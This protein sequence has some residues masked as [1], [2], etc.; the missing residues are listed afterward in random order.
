MVQL[1]HGVPG[2]GQQQARQPGLLV[3]LPR[4]VRRLDHVLGVTGVDPVAVDV[5]VQ[6]GG[7]PVPDREGG[8]AFSGVGEPVQLGQRRG[9][10]VSVTLLGQVPEH[11]TGR[12]RG[13]L[14]IIPHQAHTSA[15]VD[16]LPDHGR[17]VAGAGHPGLVDDHQRPRPHRTTHGGRR[18]LTG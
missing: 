3:G 11:P 18:T 9:G 14:L 16:D 2:R 8:C 6:G 5:V 4:R 17:Q 10:A 15:G 1:A 7:V 12:D 13:Q